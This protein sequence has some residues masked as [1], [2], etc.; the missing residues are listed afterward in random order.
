M[1]RPDDQRASARLLFAPELAS[2]RLRQA[3]LARAEVRYAVM[4][5][6]V[7]SSISRAY[8][9]VLMKRGQLRYERQ[10]VDDL[11]AARS[12]VL[13][14]DA[15]GPPRLLVRVDEFPH[16]RAWD[17]PD[18]YGTA[19]FRR[20][21]EIVAGAGMPYLVAVPA[22]VSREPLDPKRAE[23]RPL[24][25]D[26]VAQLQELRH[27]RVDFALHGLDHRTRHASPRRHA[28]LAGLKP[29]VLAERLDRA[30]A[31][32]AEA[33]AIRPDVLVP[34]YNRFDATQWQ[35]LAE[36]YAVIGGGPESVG[37]LGYHHTPMFRDGAI[38]MPAYPPLYGRAEEVLPAVRRLAERGASLWVPVVLHWGWEADAGWTALERFARE[39]AGLAVPWSGFVDAVVAS[40]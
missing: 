14:D 38:W 8:Q 26:E 23:D 6:H 35:V 37:R 20:F 28:E 4:T 31:E 17:E 5:R 11:M 1:S 39:A 16:Y 22:R 2:S 21:H 27:D 29:D 15:A 40:R 12:A 24:A 13:G 7:P 10:T 36:R 3:D 18:R 19:A 32:L 9:R 30:A 34:P 33:A 25:E